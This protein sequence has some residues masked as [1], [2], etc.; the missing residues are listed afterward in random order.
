ME[1]LQ[2]LTRR[3][4]LT[5]AEAESLMD[6][7]MEGKIS[8]AQKAALLIALKMKGE[9]RDELASFAS[10]MRRHGVHIHP[11]AQNVVDTCGTGG[12][13]SCTFNVST[14]AALIAAGAGVQ[15]AKHGNRAASGKC[16][17][18]DVLES[19]GVK[20]LLPPQVERCIDDIGIGFM[21]AP[22][23]HPAMK[24]V[25]AVRKELGVRT[26]FNMLGPLANPADAKHQ[27]LGVFS[28]ALTEDYAHVLLALG[29]ERAMVVNSE[30]MD[31]IGL[32][33][34]R[35]SELKGKKI[36]TYDMDASE[37]GFRKSDIPKANSVQE[38]AALLKGVLGGAEGAARDVAL[39]NA[40]AAIYVSGKAETIDAGLRLAEE[41]VDSGK[42]E[43]KLKML[44]DFKAE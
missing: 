31:E 35:I 28:P 16:G 21:F 43:E 37:F 33:I 12:D 36:T 34:T 17:S 7:M 40:A 5:P 20:L 38:G 10:A 30:G 29:S 4:D 32:G 25:A 2:K 22:Y 26:V 24:S 18:A 44:A 13:G 23:F 27:L 1:L 11:K 6:S 3:E 19:F 9:S 42:A 14:A 39:L 8:D 41:S 15:I